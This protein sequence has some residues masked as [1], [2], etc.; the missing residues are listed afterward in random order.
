MVKEG[1]E[2]EFTCNITGKPRPKI[3]WKKDGRI[4]SS[5]SDSKLRFLYYNLN[6]FM[7]V[8]FYSLISFHI[9]QWF[10]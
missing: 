9:V 8:L 1:D 7:L 10:I 4:L 5:N 2:V 6:D 3:Y